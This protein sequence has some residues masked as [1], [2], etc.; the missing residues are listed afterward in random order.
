MEHIVNLLSEV[1]FSCQSVLQPRP[2]LG[3]HLREIVE[4]VKILTIACN[5]GVSSRRCVT[6][7]MEL[8]NA[9][10]SSGVLTQH[11]VVWLLGANVVMDLGQVCL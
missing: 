10:V 5:S 1:D 8:G 11:G 6:P 2:H 3:E 7:T 4:Q 9:V